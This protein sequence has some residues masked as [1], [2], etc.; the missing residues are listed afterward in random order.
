VATKPSGQIQLN[1]GHA[2]YANVV[3]LLVV[4]DDGTVRELV[5]GATGTSITPV[6]GTSG[7]LGVGGGTVTAVVDMG[8]D[9]ALF[10]AASF[11]GTSAHT[12]VVYSDIPNSP[13]ASIQALATIG[14]LTA[15]MANGDTAAGVYGHNIGMNFG[16]GAAVGLRSRGGWSGNG[17]SSMAPNWY[18]ASD[19]AAILAMRCVITSGSQAWDGYIDGQAMVLNTTT[20]HVTNDVNKSDGSSDVL[21]M[22][23]NVDFVITPVTYYTVIF[24]TYLS[25]AQLDAINADPWDLVAPAGGGGFV[26]ATQVPMLGGMQKMSGGFQ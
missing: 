14:S 16:G 23:G 19:Q 15:D 5:S 24:D 21:R 22:R 10:D 18:I 20:L 26:P 6:T 2:L 13:G 11:A 7:D 3:A 25:D 1:T 17:P 12:W 8:A 9:L 4:E